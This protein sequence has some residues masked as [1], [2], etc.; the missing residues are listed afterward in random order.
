[1]GSV[2]K[3]IIAY[4]SCAPESCFLTIS[5]AISGFNTSVTCFVFSTRILLKNSCNGCQL[6]LGRYTRAS[7]QL[8]HLPTIV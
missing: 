3:M 5:A 1:M 7:N 4:F 8:F 6:V 2:V